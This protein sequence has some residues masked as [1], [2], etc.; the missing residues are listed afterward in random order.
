MEVNFLL[1]NNNEQLIPH[2]IADKPQG[3]SPKLLQYIREMWIHINY[4]KC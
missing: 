2:K 1:N 4:Y 3:P